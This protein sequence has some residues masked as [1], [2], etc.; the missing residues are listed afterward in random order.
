MKNYGTCFEALQKTQGTLF[1][2]FISSTRHTILCFKPNITK[3]LILFSL[4]VIFSASPKWE[5][6]LPSKTLVE[7][8]KSKVL[9]CVAKAKP[10]PQYHWF[11]NG[12]KINV[13]E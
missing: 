12:Q 9:T 6:P 11:R 5:K 10:N 1:I 8:T 13:S 2:E 7:T 4:Y 3:T